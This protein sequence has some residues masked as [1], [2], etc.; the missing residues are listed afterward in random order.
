METRVYTPVRIRGRIIDFPLIR[1]DL[2]SGLARPRGG[3]LRGLIIRTIEDYV[4]L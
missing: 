2:A 3:L 4:P 1:P